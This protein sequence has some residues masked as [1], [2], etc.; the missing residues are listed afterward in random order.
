[1]TFFL[2]GCSLYTVDSQYMTDEFYPS[3]T[4]DTD[5][6]YIENIDKPHDVIATIVVNTERRQTIANVLDK[7]K[8]EA[9]V[10]GGDAITNIQTNATGTWKKLP[11]QKLIGNGYV[12]ANFSAS[13]VVFK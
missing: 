5:I 10:L 3:K 1:M 11:A 8:H 12:R 9:A 4:S 7:M 6:I 2:T 13:V